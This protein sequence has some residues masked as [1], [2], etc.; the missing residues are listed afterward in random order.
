[1][2]LRVHVGIL[3]HPH[4]SFVLRV[5]VRSLAAVHL[6][7]ESFPTMTPTSERHRVRKGPPL[8]L[9]TVNAF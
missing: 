2:V 1:M 5:K 6:I 4:I 8:R 9:P 7:T 3:Q